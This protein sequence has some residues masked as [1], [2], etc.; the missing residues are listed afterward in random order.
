MPVR[1]WSCRYAS[2]R[3]EREIGESVLTEVMCRAAR[4]AKLPRA[5]ATLRDYQGRV[6]FGEQ[7]GGAGQSGRGL[8]GSGGNC[9]RDSVDVTELWGFA[10]GISDSL[11]IGLVEIKGESG[12]W[13]GWDECGIDLGRLCHPSENSINENSLIS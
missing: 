9:S 10:P 1:C 7:G 12:P 4:C 2:R 13:K 8:A 5:G 6:I 11:R 3:R